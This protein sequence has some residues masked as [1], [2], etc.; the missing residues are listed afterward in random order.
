MKSV[1]FLL[2]LFSAVLITMAMKHVPVKT[3]AYVSMDTV[4]NSTIH[5]WVNFKSM[6]HSDS[7][8]WKASGSN[9]TLFKS[10]YYKAIKD[11]AW[12]K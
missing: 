5:V 12:V 8:R 1:N 3:S 11:T 7:V 10:H 2:V 9:V 6:S 4:P